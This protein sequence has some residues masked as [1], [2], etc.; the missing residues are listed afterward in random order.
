MTATEAAEIAAVL[1]EPKPFP[2]HAL[3]EDTLATNEAWK[4]IWAEPVK[5][6][7]MARFCDG[8]A[9]DECVPVTRQSC[10]DF[11]DTACVNYGVSETRWQRW[12][13]ERA[14]T[15]SQVQHRPRSG[16]ELPPGESARPW[17]M[18]PESQPRFVPAADDTSVD[19]PAIGELDEHAT[20]VLDSFNVSHDE[21]PGPRHG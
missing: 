3:F 20:E 8:P 4:A 13:A 12:A 9:W 14:G 5:I 15:A 7:D 21:Q 16:Y 10:E 18:P 11:V 2:L 17:P 6:P 1:T 19:L